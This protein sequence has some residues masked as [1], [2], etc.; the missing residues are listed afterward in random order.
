MVVRCIGL[1][2]HFR[3]WSDGVWNLACVSVRFWRPVEIRLL[4]KQEIISIRDSG[5]FLL[6]RKSLR[7]GEPVIVI[8]ASGYSAVARSEMVRHDGRSNLGLWIFLLPALRGPNPHRTTTSPL[9]GIVDSK[10]DSRLKHIFLAN[11]RDDGSPLAF[12]MTPAREA[13]LAGG[14]TEVLQAWELGPSAR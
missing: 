4:G 5:I 10:M 13:E 6:W 1:F 3:S 14:M 9:A 2:A 7:S 11:V 12:G 8:A